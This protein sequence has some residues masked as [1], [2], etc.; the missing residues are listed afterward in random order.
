MPV[1]FSP[2]HP[3]VDPKDLARWILQSGKPIRLQL[4]IHK[5]IWGAEARGV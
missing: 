2:A 5:I 4:Q 1:L 3:M